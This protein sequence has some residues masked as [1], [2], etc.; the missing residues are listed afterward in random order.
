MTDIPAPFDPAPGPDTPEGALWRHMLMAAD[1]VAPDFAYINGQWLMRPAVRDAN[2]GSSAL[3]DAVS[4]DHSY[5]ITARAFDSLADD[6]PGAREEASEWIGEVM[7]AA[8]DTEFAEL[9]LDRTAVFAFASAYSPSE[10]VRAAAGRYIRAVSQ[11]R[12]EMA[13]GTQRGSSR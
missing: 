7:M 2:T 9:V 6:D 3:R 1:N 4:E 11:I 10:Q 5:A 13:D 8:D 12:A